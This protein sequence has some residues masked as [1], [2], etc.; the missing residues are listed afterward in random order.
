MVLGRCLQSRLERGSVHSLRLVKLYIG[1]SR[2]GTCTKRQGAVKYPEK[3]HNLVFDT[4]L[5]MCDPL[6]GS[7][8]SNAFVT[9]DPLEEEVRRL[10]NEVLLLRSQL[11]RFEEQEEEAEFDPLAEPE[12]VVDI[13]PPPAF[14]YNPAVYF[15][16]W[17]GERFLDPWVIPHWSRIVTAFMGAWIGL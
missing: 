17:K 13:D 7:S 5:S 10:Q 2:L 16:K 9:Y 1:M 11:A 4:S 6:S 3:K 8:S 12:E 15:T 14:V